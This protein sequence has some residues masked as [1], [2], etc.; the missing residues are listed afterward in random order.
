MQSLEVSSWGTEWAEKGESEET[1]IE[2]V[3]QYYLTCAQE[4]N[5]H[6]CSCSGYF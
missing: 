1:K 4:R 3:A 2:E 6:F 5:V